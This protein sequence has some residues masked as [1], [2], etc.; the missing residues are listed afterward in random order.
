MYFLPKTMIKFL[1]RLVK[2][3]DRKVFL[4]L[5]NLRIHHRYKVRDWLSE[6]EDQIELFF[7]LSY[8]PELN[9]DGYLNCD[10]KDGVH[11]GVSAKKKAIK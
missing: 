6:H 4:V 11:S 1:K 5:D 7:L 8:S 2:D 10:L 9:S 3:A